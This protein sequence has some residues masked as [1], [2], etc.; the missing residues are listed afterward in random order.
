MVKVLSLNG[1]I[2]KPCN[3]AIARLLLRQNKAKVVQ[4]QPFTIQLLYEE[5]E[6]N[7]MIRLVVTN[8]QFLAKDFMDD[9]ETKII[10]YTGFIHISKCEDDNIQEI[11]IDTNIATSELID[12]ANKVFSNIPIKYYNLTIKLSE[13]VYMFD[14]VPMNEY[15]KFLQVNN[16]TINNTSKPKV[17]MDYEESNNKVSII[18]ISNVDETT[19]ILQK[20]FG[21]SAKITTMSINEFLDRGYSDEGMYMPDI[22]YIDVSVISKEIYDAIIPYGEFVDI[23]Y[24]TSHDDELSFIN[25]KSLVNADYVKVMDELVLYKQKEKTTTKYFDI[26]TNIVPERSILV[27][28][29]NDDKRDQVIN[30]LIYQYTEN[31]CDIIDYP[32]TTNIKTL[33]LDLQKIQQNMMAT[34]AS[35]ERECVNNYKK[36]KK[37]PTQKVIIIHHLKSILANSDYKAIDAIKMSLGSIARL[38]KAGGVTLIIDTDYITS[39]DLMYNLNCVAIGKLTE[40]EYSD[41]FSS[42]M[43]SGIAKMDAN[44]ALLYNID[45]A[46]R[47]LFDIE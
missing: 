12:H 24:Y 13:P 35:M 30:N 7:N 29:K 38:G 43:P 18:N 40:K 6:N 11:Y 2:L 21:V 47:I 32:F 9:T 36:L 5:K 15:K 31:G 4:K 28:G 42:T 33:A 45:T 46:E 19:N 8:S 25:Y 22:L 37:V 26:N 16:K 20:Q 27:Y 17:T 44:K 34:F 3:N 39:F 23:I 14:A 10:D 1:N 41:L